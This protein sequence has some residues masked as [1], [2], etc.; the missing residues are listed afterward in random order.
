MGKFFVLS[1]FL[2]LSACGSPAP[3]PEKDE[4]AKLVESLEKELGVK[5]QDLGGGV[6]ESSSGFPSVCVDSEEKIIPC[7]K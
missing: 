6:Y 3:S 5:F 1:S 4:T 2:V 7:S